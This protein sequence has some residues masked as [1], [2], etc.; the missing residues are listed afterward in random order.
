M[1]ELNKLLKKDSYIQAFKR[2]VATYIYV[3]LLFVVGIGI[4]IWFLI[5]RNR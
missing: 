2:F 5:K 3:L 4:I 1:D